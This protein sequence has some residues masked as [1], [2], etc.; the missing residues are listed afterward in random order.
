MGMGVERSY[1]KDT[2]T[3]MHT[4]H[5]R[6][7]YYPHIDDPS[8]AL[9]VGPHTDAGFLTLL[10]QDENVHTLQVEDRITGKFK[11]VTP[12]A[13]AYT[14]NT[15]D[16]CVVFSNGLYHAPVH[17]VLSHDKE[18]YSS[19]YFY[20]P[21]YQSEIKPIESL[22]SGERPAQFHPLQWGYFRAMRVMGN[23]GDYGEY[24]KVDHWRKQDDGLPKHVRL[25]ERFMKSAN[26]DVPFDINT[27]ANKLK[28]ISV[29]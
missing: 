18:R 8:T 7:N 13:G 3:N 29:A 4:S 17:R 23:F 28:A 20:N 25:Q 5:L 21:S 14:V 27:Y 22:V 15:G 9:G 1:F 26:F 19:P 2:L 6:L 24:V 16:L 12:V 10:A 11:T